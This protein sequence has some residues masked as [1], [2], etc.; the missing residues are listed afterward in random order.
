MKKFL[1]VAV[2]SAMI[3]SGCELRESSDSQ[4]AVKQEQLNREANA[5]V[6]VPAIV[7][8]QERKLAKMIFEL[9][10]RSDLICYAYIVNRAN[11]KLVFVGKCIGYGLPYSV[12]YTNPQ[13]LVNKWGESPNTNSS[14]I[15][16]LP[17][18]DQ[19]GLF[20]PT[21]LSA[22]W[23]LMIDP[24]TNEPKPVYFEPEIVVSPFELN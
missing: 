8:F 19:N 12:Q 13:K 2:L 4:I 5:Q 10:D 16:V 17:Q 20:M 21:G 1:F 11:G 7:N 3:F 6:G 23:L 22:T 9:R 18:A 14:T 15:N 24:K